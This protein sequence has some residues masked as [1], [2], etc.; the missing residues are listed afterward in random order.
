M[1]ILSNIS[2]KIAQLNTGESWTLSAYDLYM[3][4]N[5][6]SSLSVF[7]VRESQNG[8]FSIIVPEAIKPWLGTTSLTVIK[9]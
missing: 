4:R 2:K 3:S 7:L 8:C 9:D 6:F 1:D 5:D